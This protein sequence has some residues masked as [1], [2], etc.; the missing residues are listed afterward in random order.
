MI[1]ILHSSDFHIGKLLYE[2]K[3]YDEFE[4]FFDWFLNCINKELIDIV[5]IA[6]DIFDTGTP[7]NKAQELYY[8]LLAGLSKSYCQ[9]VVIIGGNHDSAS[10]LQAPKNLLR[11]LNVHV[12]ASVSENL[13]DEVLVLDLKGNSISSLIVCAVPYL[14]DKDIRIVKAGESIEDKAKNLVNG[15]KEHYQRIGELALT[16]R[17][18]INAKKES[19]S[20]IPIIGM[21]HLFAAGGVSGDG[22]RDLYVGSLAYVNVDVFPTCFDYVALG[23]LHIPQRLA[24]SEYIRYSGSPLAMGF[25]EANQKKKMLL[26]EIFPNAEKNIKEISVPIFQDL[27]KISG[28]LNFIKSELV[29]LIKAESSAWLEIDYTGEEIIPDL[30]EKLEELVLESKLEICRIRNKKNLNMILQEDS[31]EEKLE[32]LDPVEV[33]NKCLEASQVLE[34][35][36]ALL[37]FSYREILDNIFTEKAENH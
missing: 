21:G 13:E 15:I 27:M 31:I 5:L 4:N 32:H 19:G 33:F 17:A 10:F 18:E 16:K 7:S 26:V 25:G 11:S 29:K 12:V 2:R 9:H 35:E 14:R 36:K 22:V 34:S 3:R 37:N 23:H 6:G 30:K 28:D 24:D 1:K 20:Y 8:K